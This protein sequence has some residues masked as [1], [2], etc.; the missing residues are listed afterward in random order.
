MNSKAREKLSVRE[1]MLG[2][3]LAP[4]KSPMIELRK[5]GVMTIIA[6]TPAAPSRDA[7]SRRI[8]GHPIMQMTSAIK[9][10]R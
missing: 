5:F 2:S 7:R 10:P 3:S 6:R 4:V 1:A 8:R 9:A